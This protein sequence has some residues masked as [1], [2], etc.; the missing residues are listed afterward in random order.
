MWCVLFVFDIYVV[1]F[2]ANRKTTTLSIRVFLRA[3]TREAKCFG[4]AAGQ[5]FNIEKVWMRLTYY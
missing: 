5:R 4:V 3:R 1:L 2:V